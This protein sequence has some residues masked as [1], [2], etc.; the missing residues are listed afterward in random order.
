[1]V[2]L[3]V[4]AGCATSDPYTNEPRPPAT[5]TIGVLFDVRE[6]ALSPRT[7]GGGPAVFI[8]TNHTGTAQ[9]VTIEGDRSLDKFK[10]GDRQ[11]RKV[12]LN[13]TLGLYTIDADQSPAQP[14]TLTVGKQRP[15]AQDQLQMP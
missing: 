9:L 7:I 6:T 15:S 8:L 4:F 2:A 13:L 14:A 3:V 11:T 12:K 1:M 5:V 10:L